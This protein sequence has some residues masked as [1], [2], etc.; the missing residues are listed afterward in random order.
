VLDLTAPVP[1][2]GAGTLAYATELVLLGHG[3]RDRWRTLPWTCLA[4]G[5]VL[6]TG[7]V[8]SVALIVIQ[9]AVA[10]HW[11]L[12]C[13]GSAALSFA[14]LALGIGEARAAAGEMRRTRRLGV[15]W[16]TALRGAS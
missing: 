15:T 7:G 1:D 5:A 12:L 8:V 2:A 4:L 10:G 6:V 13:L 16:R 3:G 9:P 14:L 11:C